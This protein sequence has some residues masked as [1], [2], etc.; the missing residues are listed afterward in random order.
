[1]SVLVASGDQTGMARFVVASTRTEIF[2][3][4]ERMKPKFLF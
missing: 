3:A 4:H 2:V 1:V